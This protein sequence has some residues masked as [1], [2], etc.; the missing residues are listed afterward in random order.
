MLSA[1]EIHQNVIARGVKRE[2]P[3]R[4]PGGF[5][6]K[7]KIAGQNIYIRTG[8][9]EDGSLG[10]VFIDMYKEGAPYRSLLNAFAIAISI[11]LQHGT[12]SK[13]WLMPLPSLDSNHL[14]L[15]KG[16]QI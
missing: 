13:D 2:L 6:Q 5:T 3:F 10:E 16:T 11:S 9:Y 7:A 12:H 15:F 1:K 8:E 14:V 4:R